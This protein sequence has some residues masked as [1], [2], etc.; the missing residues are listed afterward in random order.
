MNAPPSPP[1]PSKNSAHEAAVNAI[2]ARPIEQNPFLSSTTP[3]PV[4]VTSH[5][6]INLSTDGESG[7]QVLVDGEI[8]SSSNPQVVRS[9]SSGRSPVDRRPQGAPL[10]VD[11]TIVTPHYKDPD[12]EFRKGAWRKPLFFLTLAAAFVAALAYFVPSKTPM[13]VLESRPESSRAAIGTSVSPEVSQLDE[14]ADNQGSLQPIPKQKKEDAKAPVS[15]K[16]SRQVSFATAFKK[17]AS[18]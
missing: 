11:P 7:A 10:R 4:P 8:L 18:P 17:E 16:K 12:A 2:E 6:D 14:Q 1:R 9:H 13:S 15:Q 3:D 5:L